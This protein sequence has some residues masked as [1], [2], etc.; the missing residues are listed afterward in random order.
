MYN[1]KT[2]KS[3]KRMG[4]KRRVLQTKEYSITKVIKKKIKDS[5]E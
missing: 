4:T 3:K 5:K 1:K 2:K